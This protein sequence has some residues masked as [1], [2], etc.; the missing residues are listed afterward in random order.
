MVQLQQLTGCC[1]FQIVYHPA[2]LQLMLLLLLPNRSAARGPKTE[3]ANQS[4]KQ[5]LQQFLPNFNNIAWTVAALGKTSAAL[6][7]SKTITVLL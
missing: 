7:P 5:V 1:H 3:D 4:C 2:L 6:E